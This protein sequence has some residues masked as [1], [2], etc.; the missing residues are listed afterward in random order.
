MK[1]SKIRKNSTG[2]GIAHVALVSPAS[3]LAVPMTHAELRAPAPADA[4]P[5]P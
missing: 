3:Y 1:K 2:P 5:A 4:D